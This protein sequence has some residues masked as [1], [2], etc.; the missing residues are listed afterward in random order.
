M[1]I[2]CTLTHGA[3]ELVDL[4]QGQRVVQRLQWVNWGH[5]RA[6]FKSCSRAEGTR[7]P[8]AHQMRLRAAGSTQ[9]SNIPKPASFYTSTPHRDAL[10]VFSCSYNCHNLLASLYHMFPSRQ[11]RNHA[12]HQDVI[13]HTAKCRQVHTDLDLFPNHTTK[14]ITSNCKYIIKPMPFCWWIPAHKEAPTAAHSVSDCS[15]ASV[16]QFSSRLLQRHRLGVNAFQ[17][18]H[19]CSHQLEQNVRRW[20]CTANRQEWHAGYSQ[21][22]FKQSR[23]SRHD[24]M[25]G[26]QNPHVG[27]KA[28]LGAIWTDNRT[29]SV[30]MELFTSAQC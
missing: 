9:E 22:G 30:H 6:A 1:L 3:E 28:R 27:N 14:I 25:E 5:H 24:T 20:E 7:C 18:F 4:F 2:S 17:C 11:G 15:S 12:G 29:V 8:E 13:T 23:Q 10:A 21:G 26:H 19:I 16:R